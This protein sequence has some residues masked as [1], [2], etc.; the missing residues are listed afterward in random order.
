MPAQPGWHEM[1]AAGSQ[2][3]RLWRS[4]AQKSSQIW[5][6]PGSSGLPPAVHQIMASTLTCYEHAGEKSEVSNLA[7]C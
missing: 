2:L 7:L 3:L 1:P 4:K 5:S 6:L